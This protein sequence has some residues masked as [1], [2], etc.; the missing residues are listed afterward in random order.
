MFGDGD[1]GVTLYRKAFGGDFSSTGFHGV[2]GADF[3]LTFL[4]TF[5]A[6]FSVPGSTVIYIM[7]K[8]GFMI[9]ANRDIA[10]VSGTTLLNAK[11]VCT[12]FYLHIPQL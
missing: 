4:K 2:W 1:V 11:N 10:V 7:D 5:V 8:D 9:A 3:T 6:G 12:L